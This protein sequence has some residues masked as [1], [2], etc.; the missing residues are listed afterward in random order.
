[1]NVQVTVNVSD[2]TI[3]GLLC[4]AFEGG[5]NYWYMITSYDKRKPK[6]EDPYWPSY[7]TTPI[8]EDGA[9][10]ID[11]SAT[12]ETPHLRK[13]VRLD[14]ARLQKGLEIM[15]KDYPA[16]FAD[17]LAEKDDATTGDVFLQCCIFGSLIYG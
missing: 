12:G 15:A 7:L 9:I 11:D 14:R 8:S 10:Y 4:S 13:P 6:Q 17:V 1:M 3:M 2:E 5:S 16:H